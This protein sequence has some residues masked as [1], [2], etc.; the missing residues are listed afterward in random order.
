MSLPTIDS[1][2]KEISS[3]QKEIDLEEK[4]SNFLL[5]KK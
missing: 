2:I 4:V 5:K 1:L 3:L